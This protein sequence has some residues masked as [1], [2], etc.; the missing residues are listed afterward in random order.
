MSAT[1]ARGSGRRT[2]RCSGT[3]TRPAASTDRRLARPGPRGDRPYDDAA[4]AFRTNK[5]KYTLGSIGGIQ[6]ARAAIP[7]STTGV[8]P[9]APRIA[10]R[11][12]LVVRKPLD[13]VNAAV[14]AVRTA[15]L[16]AALAALS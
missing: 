12:V 11:W 13:E 14:A 2:S 8:T 7:F 1:S 3:Q 5:S 16:Y 15:F 4:A 10:Q 6:Y 9:K